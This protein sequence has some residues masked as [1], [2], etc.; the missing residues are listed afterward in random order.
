MSNTFEK[1]E[2]V[3][4]ELGNL[5]SVAIAFSGGAD[6]TLLLETARRLEVLRLIAVTVRTPLF[7][8]RE[9]EEAALFCRERSIKQITVDVDPFAIEGF[10]EN[11]PERCYI[12][13]RKMFETMLVAAREAGVDHIAEG[14][15]ADDA[16]DYRPGMRAV[17][18]LGVMS[19]LLDAGLTK[20][21]IRTL[22]R[23]MGLAVS[24]KPSFAC[25]AT[26]FPH[27]ERITPER[28]KA[29]GE[30][31]QLLLDMGFGR[32]RVRAHGDTARIEL[33]PDDIPKA[34]GMAVSIAPP[35]H[36]M[37]FRYVS[38]DLDGYRTGSMNP[39]E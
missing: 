9:Y 30:A 1:L 36:E 39:K 17:R 29:V 4:A 18:E 32:V 21:E 19:P 23:E 3:K 31:E 24:E 35:L 14:S 11:P 28:A 37:G 5:G 7:P 16:G 6:S 15:N 27:G 10:A 34:A 2:K 25:L 20:S 38:L 33:D 22:L 8:Q 12:C 26:R 13:K